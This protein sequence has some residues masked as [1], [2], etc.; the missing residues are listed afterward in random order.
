MKKIMAIALTV[1][2]LLTCFIA[3]PVSADNLPGVVNLNIVNPSFEEDEVGATTFTG[4]TKNYTATDNVWSV[5][6]GGVNGSNRIS[7]KANTKF[8]DIWLSQVVEIPAEIAPYMDSY[9]WFFKNYNTYCTVIKIKLYGADGTNYVEKSFDDFNLR[10]GDS[11]EAIINIT[12]AMTAV[13]NPTKVE[14]AINAHRNG[15]S[16]DQIEL[17]GTT[18]QSDSLVDNSSLSAVSPLSGAMHNWTLKSPA[19]TNMVVAKNDGSGDSYVVTL[20]NEDGAGWLE[21]GGNTTELVENS[22]YML[23]IKYKALYSTDAFVRV[24]GAVKAGFYFDGTLPA[25]TPASAT[26]T[27]LDQAEWKTYRMIFY[28]ADNKDSTHENVTIRLSAHPNTAKVGAW[29]D[30]ISLVPVTIPTDNHIINGDFEMNEAGDTGIAGWTHTDINNP[31][32]VTSRYIASGTKAADGA[33]TAGIKQTVTMTDEMKAKKVYLSFRSAYVGGGQMPSVTV[34]AKTPAGNVSYKYASCKWRA[35]WSA[36]AGE[37]EQSFKDGLSWEYNREVSTGSYDPEPFVIDLQNLFDMTDKSSIT[38]LEIT[39]AGGNGGSRWDDIK[40]YTVGGYLTGNNINLVTNGD[41]ATDLDG[42]TQKSATSQFTW[43]AGSAVSNKADAGIKQVI[44]I[45]PAADWYRKYKDYKFEFSYKTQS[46]SRW[47]R[48]DATVTATGENGATA[49]ALFASGLTTPTG[50]HN[51]LNLL[52]VDMA[53]LLEKIGDQPVKQFEISIDKNAANDGKVDDVKLVVSK[54]EDVAVN[55]AYAYGFEANNEDY[56][57]YLMTDGKGTEGNNYICLTDDSV[58]KYITLGMGSAEIPANGMYMLQF[59]YKQTSTDAFIKIESGVSGTEIAVQS[60]GMGPTGSSEENAAWKTFTGVFRTTATDTRGIRL[61]LRSWSKTK[62]Y[63]DNVRITKIENSDGN[64]LLNGNFDLA[65]V[66][67]STFIPGWTNVEAN[68]PG[69]LKPNGMN[70]CDLQVP[71]GVANVEQTVPIAYY[72]ECNSENYGYKLT[73]DMRY[74]GAYQSVSA[75]FKFADGS[76]ETRTFTI[77]AA[78]DGSTDRIALSNGDWTKGLSRDLTSTAKSH[79]SPITSITIRF[80]SGSEGAGYDNVKLTVIKPEIEITDASGAT[81]D[82]VTTNASATYKAKAVYYGNDEST[83]VWLNIYTVG[84]DGNLRL[85]KAANGAIAGDGVVNNN[86][87]IEGVN[88]VA[89]TT[90]VKAFIWGT[91]LNPIASTTID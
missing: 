36:Y 82:E 31:M 5:E 11:H 66:P 55:Y 44:T 88:A 85:T 72:D 24:G 1:A 70:T 47:S 7:V 33:G 4:W 75:I 52:G 14:I 23:S 8:T 19:S 57:N 68:K 65:A 78:D 64:L 40:L 62:V 22:Y 58:G 13:A 87:T 91:E 56:T 51:S 20:K 39:F 26:V 10:K 29:Y 34:V 60:E 18:P 89:G 30:E 77:Y 59:D 74:A 38:A 42:W 16:Y 50:S 81:L 63:Y 71:K 15:N 49:S 76:T 45:D 2:M 73:W 41:F 61:L 79:T 69:V 90:V 43:S 25:T 54:K 48:A 86:V 6:A 12:S 67:G 84:A 53:T 46:N 17:F 80:S 83:M 9:S 21:S 3:M 27:T 37:A 28:T 35:D 32:S